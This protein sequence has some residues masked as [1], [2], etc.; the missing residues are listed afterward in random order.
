[1]DAAGISTSD[2][3]KVTK[4]NGQWYYNGKSTKVGNGQH[5]ANCEKAIVFCAGGS[6]FGYGV[7]QAIAIKAAIENGGTHP[8]APGTEKASSNTAATLA[9]APT[10]PSASKDSKECALRGDTYNSKQI[11]ANCPS[12][13]FPVGQKF[14]VDGTTYTV[15]KS[16]D[17]VGGSTV[18][19]ARKSGR[20]KIRKGTKITFTV[21]D[22]TGTNQD[23]TLGDEN[24]MHELKQF[25]DEK[26]GVPA[27]TIRL[28]CKGKML[29]P[30]KGK[31]EANTTLAD[32]KIKNKDR[33]FMNLNLR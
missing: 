20:G 7:K 29:A 9:L 12:S 4:R 21:R 25:L 6:K 27:D 5:N 26:M 15:T 2:Q 22:L 32:L 24:T 8:S 33:I 16:W 30:P 28:L 3:S 1:L 13:K 17:S 11:P 19:H 31:T 23:V 14:C 10:P 18:N